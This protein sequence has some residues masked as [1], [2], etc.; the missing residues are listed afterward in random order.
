MLE[1][2]LRRAAPDIVIFGEDAQRLPNTLCFAAPGMAAETALIALDLAGI[3]VSSGSACSS[4]KVKVSHVL[5]AMGVP[6]HLAACALR[7]SLG[8]E[9]T[10]EDITF[11]GAVWTRLRQ[12]LHDREQHRAA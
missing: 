6:P 4:G 3:S 12:S 7:V 10:A 8:R 9:S 11:F 2:D 5:S 1:G